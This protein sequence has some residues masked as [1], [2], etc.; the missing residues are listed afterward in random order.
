[1]AMIDPEIAGGVAIRPQVIG[2]HPI[3]NEAIFLQKFAHQS[4][5][6][7]LVSL[8][9]YQHIENLAFGVDGAYR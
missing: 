3:W 7:V 4:Q 5:R 8:G 6:G 9:L 2:D 1:M